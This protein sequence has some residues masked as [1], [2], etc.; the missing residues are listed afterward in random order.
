MWSKNDTDEGWGSR[1]KGDDGAA[2]EQGG[3][4]RS[5]EQGAT[6]PSGVDNP[7]GKEWRKPERSATRNTNG[8]WRKMAAAER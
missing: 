2:Y 7:E 6:R 4:K 1:G 3:K 5:R 8:E